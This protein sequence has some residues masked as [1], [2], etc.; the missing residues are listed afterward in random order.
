M[1]LKPGSVGLITVIV[2]D[3]EISP[4]LLR[5]C[6]ERLPNNINPLGQ[7]GNLVASTRPDYHERY[8]DSEGFSRCDAALQYEEARPHRRLLGDKPLALRRSR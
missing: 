5:F 7:A 6:R 1:G 4:L 2:D 8:F 3:K